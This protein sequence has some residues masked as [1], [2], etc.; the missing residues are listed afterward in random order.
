MDILINNAGLAL[1]LASVLDNDMQ[2]WRT[3]IE[4][5]VTSVI[6]LTKLFVRGMVDR[7]R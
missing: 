4:T 5:N 2:D 7:N 3:M 1:G 6:L